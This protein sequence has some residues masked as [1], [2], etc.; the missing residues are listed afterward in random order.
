MEQLSAARAG[1]TAIIDGCEL[2]APSVGTDI[3]LATELAGQQS[4]L[5]ELLAALEEADLLDQVDAIHLSDL[6]QLTMDY[7]G[8]FA[9]EMAYG[10]DYAW[11]LRILT[12]ASPA[13]E[14]P[15]GH[16]PPGPG[17]ADHRPGLT[18]RGEAD[19][20]GGGGPPPSFP[21]KNCGKRPEAS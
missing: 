7:A 8:R 15:D 11:Q 3:A 6:S 9:V 2:L 4:S 12:A 20:T 17:H 10:A 1:T 19:E 13:G 21:S 5:L 16:H 18:P 14:Q